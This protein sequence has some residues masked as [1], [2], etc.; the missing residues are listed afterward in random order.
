MKH[1]LVDTNVIIDVLSRDSAHMDW[2]RDTLEACCARGLLA[3]NPI[4]YAELSAGIDSIE[5]IEAALPADDRARLEL[6][7]EAAFLA[8]RAFATY[9]A[10]GGQHERALP[11]FYIGAHAALSGLTLVTRDATRYRT[12]FPRLDVIAP[13]S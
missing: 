12:Y 11:D 8:G 1:F 5:V 2:S 3:I 7:W 10:R 9:R 13:R 6:P 4:I